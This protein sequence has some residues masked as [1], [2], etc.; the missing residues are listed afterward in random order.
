MEELSL[1]KN[2][3]GMGYLDFSLKKS[4]R[5]SLDEDKLTR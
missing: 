4:E 3:R 1:A 2:Q 5:Q